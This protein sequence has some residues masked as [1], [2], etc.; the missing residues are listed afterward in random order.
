MSGFIQ[1]SL[2][3]VKKQY[4]KPFPF[5]VN[6]NVSL[7][8]PC[9]SVSTFFAQVAQAAQGPGL[10]V[11]KLVHS[12]YQTFKVTLP[13]IKDSSFSTLLVF[14]TPHFAL[15]ALSLSFIRMYKA[16][17]YKHI[18]LIGQDTCVLCHRQIMN[19]YCRPEYGDTGFSLS[20][21]KHPKVDLPQVDP[22]NF[23]VDGY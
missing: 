3:T 12:Y 14:N 4:V 15:A 6:F 23:R 10:S 16:G 21:Q 5:R 11:S 9:I 17:E 8:V 1:C 18:I 13:N 20:F 22:M 7:R 19:F 2:A